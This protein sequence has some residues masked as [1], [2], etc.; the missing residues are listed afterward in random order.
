MN[1][2]PRHHASAHASRYYSHDYPIGP[3]RYVDITAG[4]EMRTLPADVTRWIRH[5]SDVIQAVERDVTKRHARAW[6][7]VVTVRVEICESGR[8]YS[9][10]LEVVE[11]GPGPWGMGARR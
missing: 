6:P 1:E 8:A 10:R 9:T 4:H 11:D 3:V 5:D 2:R 7:R